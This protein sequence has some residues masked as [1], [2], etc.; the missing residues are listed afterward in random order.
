MA[1]GDQIS[2][3]W[4][5]EVVEHICGVGFVRRG[6]DLRRSNIKSQFAWF[7]GFSHSTEPWWLRDVME[8]RS[9]RHA[10]V[11]SDDGVHVIIFFAC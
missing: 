4:S 5:R 11:T 10:C 7:V 9:S 3:F 8:S 1:L 2:G 6:L